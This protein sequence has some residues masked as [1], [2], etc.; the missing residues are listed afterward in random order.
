MRDQPIYITVDNVIFYAEENEVFVLLIQ[1]KNDPYKSKW[2]LP[3]GFLEEEETLE[4]GAVR[5]LKEETGIQVSSLKQIGI[6]A[7]PGRDPRGRIISIAFAGKAASQENVK[8]D[9]DAGDARWFNLKNIPP[10]AFDHL[11]IIE[12]AKEIL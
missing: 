1:R 6:F 12:S 5:E 10:V 9:D 8:A 4:T 2:A 7:D 11:N 3:G